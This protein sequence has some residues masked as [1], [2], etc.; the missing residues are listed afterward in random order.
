MKGLASELGCSPTT[1]RREFRGWTGVPL[2]RYH[3]GLRAKAALQGLL[4]SDLKIDAL[5]EDLGY[6]SK[7]NMYR[8]LRASCGLTP[9]QIRRLAPE[10]VTALLAN[11]GV[12][13]S[14]RRD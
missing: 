7:K 3:H 11:L 4:A 8:T 10:E 2:R 14:L 13:V 5:A 6:K 9:R 1:L 12:R